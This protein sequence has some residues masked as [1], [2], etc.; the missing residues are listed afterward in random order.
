MCGSAIGCV[1]FEERIGCFNDPPPRQAR[2]FID[3]LSGF[4]KYQQPLM[5]GLPIYKIFP[6]TAWRTFETYADQLIKQAQ[7][8]VVKVD[9]CL[10]L[11]DK[12]VC[13]Y[14]KYLHHLHFLFLKKLCM[15]SSCGFSLCYSFIN[16]SNNFS[17]ID[18]LRSRRFYMYRY[19]KLSS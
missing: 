11:W 13:F 9:S 14:F 17:K 3:S 18:T 6:T 1:L 2:D 8:F 19:W 5:Y 4:F 10:F 15:K 7:Q 12:H 16:R